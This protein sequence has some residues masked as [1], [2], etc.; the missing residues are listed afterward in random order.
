M[1]DL[2][3]LTSPYS[4][5]RLYQENLSPLYLFPASDIFETLPN[6]APQLSL[7]H[8]LFLRLPSD[9]KT[10]PRTHLFVTHPYDILGILGFNVEVELCSV[11]SMRNG[12]LGQVGC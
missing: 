10:L 7:F 4:S 3:P 2:H 1:I 5:P 11:I 12:R 6:A 8:P 9:V